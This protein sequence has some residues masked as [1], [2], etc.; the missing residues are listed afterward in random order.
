[1]ADQ[2][3]RAKAD[4]NTLSVRLRYRPLR[5]G[6]CVLKGDMES[7]RRSVRLSFTMWGGRY[8]PI[9]VVD[10]RE[11]AEALVKLFRVDVLVQVSQGSAVGDFVQA[12]NYY[13]PS[14]MIGGGLFMPAMPSGKVPLI[15]D[16][17]HPVIRLHEQFFRNN[18]TP[19]SGLDL[20]EWEVDD[21]LVDVFLCSYG[22]FPSTDAVAVAIGRS[23]KQVCSA[24]GTSSKTVP[25]RRCRMQ[26]ETRSLA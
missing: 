7:F 2:Y 3:P 19:E 24:S 9:I 1:V 22:E 11:I 15:V 4:M 16:I 13:L 10:D 23:S 17:R 25:K 26:S 14:P 8:N 20:Y 12:H 6:W 5:L 18:P 21:P